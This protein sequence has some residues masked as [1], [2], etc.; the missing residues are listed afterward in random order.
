MPDWRGVVDQQ[1]NMRE[2]T[3]AQRDEIVAE[4][5]GHLEE[6]CDERH[7]A[8]LSISQAA[9]T[10]LAEVADWPA[11]SR[12]IEGAKLKEGVMNQRTKSIWIPGL[13]TL[14]FT[15]GALAMLE[16][17][18]VQP[19]VTW[20][21]AGIGLVFYTPWLIAQPTFGAIGAYLSRRAGGGRCARLTS[22]LFPALMMLASFFVILGVG[23]V[24]RMLRV[25][26]D[27][28]PEVWP[29]LAAHFGVWVVIPGFALAL[30]ALPFL[31][32]ARPQE[33]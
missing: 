25:S 19:H 9:D 28:R 16:V 4:L 11:L 17:W 14:I 26:D 2:L 5:A 27:F 18:R 20:M 12:R 7:A 32:A 33:S 10:A 1:L 29:I 23:F 6:I 21:R 22:G 30:G 15:S 13:I 31:G 8:G 3:S 24:L